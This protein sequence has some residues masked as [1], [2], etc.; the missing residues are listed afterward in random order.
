MKK[1]TLVLATLLI[2]INSFAQ[3]QKKLDKNFSFVIT[4]Q[5]D[6]VA[7]F[8]LDT[9]VKRSGWGD[10]NGA[11]THAFV[12][13]G[14]HVNSRENL[15]SKHSFSLVIDYGRGFFAGKMQY[16]DLKGQ[17]L[18][19]NTNSEVVGT[20]TYDGRFNT[21]EISEAIATALKSK[22][23]VIVKEE[24]RKVEVIKNE[25]QNN[26]TR[27]SKEDRLRELKNLYEKELITKEEYEKA[28]QKI[29][30]EQ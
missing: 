20:F 12:S 23:P 26:Q 11:L 24:E 19:I 25:S 30:E 1:S 9:R 21:D 17:I 16:F 18:S 28:K 13:K 14:F 15:N 5:L 8:S 3:G 29:L 4:G 10:F 2:S 27:K 22:N 6:T 7:S